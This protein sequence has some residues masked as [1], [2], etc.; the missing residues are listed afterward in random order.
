[1][2]GAIYRMENGI[3][4]TCFVGDWLDFRSAYPNSME[5]DTAKFKIYDG[6]FN[7]KWNELSENIAEFFSKRNSIITCIKDSKITYQK[8]YGSFDN[9][10]I[11]SP[12]LKDNEIVFTEKEVC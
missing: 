1:M 5:V 4:L 12:A 6:V 3:I 10:I 8:P 9:L 11:Y 2:K 7:L